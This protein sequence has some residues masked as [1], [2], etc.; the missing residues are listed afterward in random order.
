[1]KLKSTSLSP[2]ERVILAV[3]AIA[4]TVLFVWQ[5]VSTHAL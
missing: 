5:V 3:G 4:S 2:A 1:V